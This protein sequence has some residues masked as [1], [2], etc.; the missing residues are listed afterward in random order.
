M[1][2]KASLSA[3]WLAGK[4]Q[5]Y[6]MIQLLPEKGGTREFAHPPQSVADEKNALLMLNIAMVFF[7][8]CLAPVS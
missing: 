1:I 6:K 2:D 8:H 4:K 7:Q 3:E 5:R